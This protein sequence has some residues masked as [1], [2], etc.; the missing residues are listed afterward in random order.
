MG[1]RTG[2][3]F[4][5][6]IQAHSLYFPPAERAPLMEDIFS[7]QAAV[8]APTGAGAYLKRDLPAPVASNPPPPVGERSAAD[9]QP[10]SSPPTLN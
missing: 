2:S 9:R 7:S 5:P 1:D 6:F 8:L 3:V 4:S 10:H